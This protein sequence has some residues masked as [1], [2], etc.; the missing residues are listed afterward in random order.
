MRHK[1][2]ITMERR[3]QKRKIQKSRGKKELKRK[4]HGKKEDLCCSIKRKKSRIELPVSCKNLK[5][6]RMTKKKKNRVTKSNSGNSRWKS[7]RGSD[8]DGRA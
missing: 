7:M 5:K 6:L 1:R 3:K 8:R 4:Q 2:K